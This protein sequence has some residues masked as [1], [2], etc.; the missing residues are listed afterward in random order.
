MNPHPEAVLITGASR[1]IGLALAKECLDLG[2]AVVIHYRSTPEPALT[3]LRGKSVYFLQ[4][5]LGHSPQSLID[6]ALRLPLTLSGLINN[7]SVFTPGNLTNPLHLEEVISVNALIPA[8]LGNSFVQ[9]AKDGKWII[10]ITDAHVEPLN[11]NYQNYR[12]SKKLFNDITRQMAFL[13]SPK[14]RVNAIAPGAILP[15]PQEQNGET[16]KKLARKIP[17]GKTGDPQF[18]RHTLRFLIQNE[19]I[20]GEIIKVDGGWHLLD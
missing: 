14:I 17:L 6:E 16:F 5:E 4:Q 13:Y 10:N 3:E 8:K 11:V 7:A 20:N 2:Y 12:I 9:S 19:Y 15:S 1:R 18:I